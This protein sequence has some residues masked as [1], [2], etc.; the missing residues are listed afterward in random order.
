MFENYGICD[1]MNFNYSKFLSRIK[2]IYE[3]VFF[4][5]KSHHFQRRYQK[6]IT[7][8]IFFTLLLYFLNT[9]STAIDFYRKA[10]SNFLYNKKISFFFSAKVSKFKETMYS[11]YIVISSFFTFPIYENIKKG[12]LKVGMTEDGTHLLV[13]FGCWTNRAGY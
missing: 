1:T 5:A 4:T 7:D 6:E 12:A 8:W 13:S 3:K 9:V 2:I 11:I 10:A